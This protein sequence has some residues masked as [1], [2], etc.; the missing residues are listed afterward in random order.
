MKEFFRRFRR[1]GVGVW[2]CIQP[3]EVQVPEGRVQVSPGTRF[4]RGTSFMNV[5]MAALLDEE[6]DRQNG[7]P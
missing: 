7:R 5:E 3:A 2:V 4:T 1:E 6:Y